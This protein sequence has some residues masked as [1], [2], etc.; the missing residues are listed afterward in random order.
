METLIKTEA[1]NTGFAH[2]IKQSNGVV[3]IEF[4][5]AATASAVA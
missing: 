2:Y 1:T 4:A 3:V 5:E